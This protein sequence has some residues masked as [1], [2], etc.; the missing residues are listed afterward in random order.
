MLPSRPEFSPVASICMHFAPLVGSI[1][2]IMSPQTLKGLSGC[3]TDHRHIIITI[4]TMCLCHELQGRTGSILVYSK[5][6]RGIKKLKAVL[7]KGLI[8]Y[9]IMSFRLERLFNI[10]IGDESMKVVGTNHR[11]HHKP[12]SGPR[13]AWTAGSTE[14]PESLPVKS[15]YFPYS[16]S[17]SSLVSYFYSFR[18]L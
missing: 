2:E 7:V 10:V 11:Y 17:P 13:S 15:F 1:S 18:F 6:I 5:D 14:L 9:F 8:G 3:R 4:T 16:F 12:H